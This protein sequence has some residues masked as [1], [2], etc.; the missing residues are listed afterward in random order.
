MNF[1]TVSPSKDDFGDV[2]TDQSVHNC[3]T[4]TVNTNQP[5]RKGSIRSQ[6]KNRKVLRPERGDVKEVQEPKG[7]RKSSK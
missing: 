6:F 5:S 3:T 4:H 2:P 1:P 7:K